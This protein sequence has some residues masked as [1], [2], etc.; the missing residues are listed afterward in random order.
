MNN[1]W[2]WGACFLLCWF[3]GLTALAATTNHPTNILAVRIPLVIDRSQFS[4]GTIFEYGDSYLV[5][6]SRCIPGVPGQVYGWRIRGLV[7]LGAVWVREKLTLPS[8][9]KTWG[10]QG[11]EE[12]RFMISGDRTSCFWERYLPIVNETVGNCWVFAEGDPRGIYEIQVTLDG[13]VLDEIRFF[14]D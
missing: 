5:D 13:V 6:E 14:V 1:R 9:P 11:N 4:F 7:G 8:A 10:E 12:G 2:A 3:L